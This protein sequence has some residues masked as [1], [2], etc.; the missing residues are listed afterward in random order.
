MMKFGL[1]LRFHPGFRP[2]GRS[3]PEKGGSTPEGGPPARRECGLRIGILQMN[4]S[5][6]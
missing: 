1:R 5:M 6:T 3:S 4:D 2:G